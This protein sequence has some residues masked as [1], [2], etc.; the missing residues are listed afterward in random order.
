VSAQS[1]DGSVAISYDPTTDG[2]TAT[3]PVVVA[4][5]TFTG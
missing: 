3:A 5:P 1:G 4:N 2:C